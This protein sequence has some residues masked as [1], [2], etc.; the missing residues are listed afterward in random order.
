MRSMNILSNI[1]YNCFA[2]PQNEIKYMHNNSLDD[3]VQLEMMP[4]KIA[5]EARYEEIKQFVQNIIDD[6]GTS[7]ILSIMPNDVNSRIDHKIDR[8][9]PSIQIKFGPLSTKY[10]ASGIEIHF[11]SDNKLYSS[12][13]TFCADNRIRLEKTNADVIGKFLAFMNL[14]CT[15]INELDELINSNTFLSYQADIDA[16][17]KAKDKLS[18]FNA[19]Q[20]FKKIAVMTDNFNCNAKIRTN[21]NVFLTIKKITH[22]RLYVTNYRVNGHERKTINK[23]LA[24][25]Y[26]I[27]NKWSYQDLSD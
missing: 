14:L 24:A 20:R 21:N 8:Y 22:Q 2:N 12:V 7:D 25:Q 4:A 11:I 10:V 15:K 18:Q 1:Q 26:I 16:Y 27:D 23:K 5:S 17:F 13:R 6:S 3:A 9:I 19:E